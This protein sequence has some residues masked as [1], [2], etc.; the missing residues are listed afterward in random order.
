MR[1]NSHNYPRGRTLRLKNKG[2]LIILGLAATCGL[3][4]LPVQAA[5]TPPDSVI[6]YANYDPNPGGSPIGLS[7]RNSG[8]PAYYTGG[9]GYASREAVAFTTDANSYLLDLVSIDVTRV[10]GDPADLTV[11]LYGDVGGTPGTSL[12]T[13]SNADS[14]AKGAR[15]FT[16]TP[17][18]LE[19]DTTYWIVAEPS[20]LEQNDFQWWDSVTGGI[21]SSS[22]LDTGTGLWDSWISE[23]SAYAPSVAVYG[24]PVPE[25]STLALAGLG[26]VTLLV[27][28]R[29][30]F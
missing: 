9:S 6:I 2:K 23:T 13:F 5:W 1:N 16:T 27:F 22:A 24:A 12:L 26:V 3:V 11:S 30:L 29:R 14:I 8:G 4:G 25:P 18:T 28:R 20:F 21:D 7:S 15:F 10:L 19:S 17:F